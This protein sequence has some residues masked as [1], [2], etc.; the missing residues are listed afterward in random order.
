MLLKHQKSLGQLFLKTR[1]RGDLHKKMVKR[2][3]TCKTEG[4]GWVKIIISNS[5]KRMMNF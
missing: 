4:E 5:Q 3:T 2:M 1:L